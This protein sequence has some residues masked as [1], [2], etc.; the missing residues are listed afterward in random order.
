MGG[1]DPVADRRSSRAERQ[2]RAALPTVAESLAD[3]QAA[4]ASGSAARYQSEVRRLCDRKIAPKL[5]KRVLAETVRADWTR[6]VTAVHRRAPA[7]GA[8]LYRTSAAFLG[9]AEL[10]GWIPVFVAAATGRNAHS[11]THCLA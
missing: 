3:R 4:K 11:A 9:H 7:V 2:A 10:L 6:M 5:W 8:M 1:G